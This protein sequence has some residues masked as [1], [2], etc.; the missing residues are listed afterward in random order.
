MNSRQASG[1]KAW[2]MQRL[3]A[4]YLAVFSLYLIGHFAY[5]PAHHYSDLIQWLVTPAV[6][7][8]MLLFIPLLLIHAWIGGRNIAIDYLKPFTLRLGF[9]ILFAALLFASGLWAGQALL[10]AHFN[11]G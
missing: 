2:F 4:A 3:T 10:R 5:A 9:L 7:L 11:A 1:L 6:F 8:G